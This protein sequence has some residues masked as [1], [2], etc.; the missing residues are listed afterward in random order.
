MPIRSCKGCIKRK[1]LSSSSLQSRSK[2]WWVMLLGSL[3]V[4]RKSS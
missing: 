1:K 3:K 2:C 4:K